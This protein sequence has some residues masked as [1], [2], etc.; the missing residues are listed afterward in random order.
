M[1]YSDEVMAGF[2]IGGAIWGLIPLIIGLCKKRGGL[3][4]L[5]MTVCAVSALASSTLPATIACICSIV[6]LFVPK[7]NKAEEKQAQDQAMQKYQEELAAQKQKEQQAKREEEAA[8]ARIKYKNELE[9]GEVYQCSNC[10][11]I[12]KNTTKRCS[13]GILTPYGQMMLDQMLQAKRAN[14]LAELQ[15][16][17]EWQCADCGRINK[18]KKSKCFCGYSKEWSY[19]QLNKK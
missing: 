7:S 14:H 6:L 4:A 3:G 8:Q 17:E 15:S 19:Q 5:F 16:G 10:G 18:A 11:K 13:C 2:L 9:R 1:S 12:N